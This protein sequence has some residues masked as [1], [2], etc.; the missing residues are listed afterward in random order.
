VASISSVLSVLLQAP[1][2]AAQNWLN[3]RYAPNITPGVDHTGRD[4]DLPPELRR[5]SLFYRSDYPTGT[6]I[7][8]TADHYLY[9]I[10]GN[11]VAPRY[12]IGVGRDGFP[13]GRHPRHHAQGGMAGPDPAA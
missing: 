1:P 8:N 6:I 13:V 11:N 10:M 3:P 5:T 12:G 2:A 9:L 7:V 4:K